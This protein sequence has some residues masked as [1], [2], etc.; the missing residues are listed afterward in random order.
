MAVLEKFHSDVVNF[1]IDGIRMIGNNRTGSI[2]GLDDNGT[3]FVENIARGEEIDVTGENEILYSALKEGHYFVEDEKS[4]NKIVSA[5]FHVTDRCNFHC[6]GCYSY[7]DSRNSKKDLSIEQL[8]YELDELAE[9]GVK[10]IVISG[11]EPFLREDIDEICKYAKKL[12]M[13]TNIITNGTM[14]DIRYKKALPYIDGISVSVDGYNEKT[15]FI[16]DKGTMPIVLGTVKMLK[17]Q[18]ANVNLIFTLHHKNAS[19]LYHYKK[20]A[21]QLEVT[22]N[23]SILTASPKESIFADYVL[24]KED[25]DYMEKFLNHNKAVITDSAMESEGLSCKSRCGAGKLLV[26]IAADGTVYPCHMLHVQELSLG[27]VLDSKLRDIVFN[28]NNPFLN[29]DIHN[30]KECDSCKYGNFCGGGCRARSYLQTG[31]IYKNSDICGVSYN[32]L[33][34]KFTGLKKAYGL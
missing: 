24:R 34:R 16:R 1:Q 11:G 23:F 28:E 10:A 22:Y 9:N 17:E 13:I 14:P 29:L 32:N 21:E 12:G 5:Y 7:V 25:F 20:L 26:S 15:S 8:F 3:N 2:I 4:E 18:G 27:N 19:Y 30:I 6:L 33:D 31:S